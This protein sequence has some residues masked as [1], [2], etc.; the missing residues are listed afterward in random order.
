MLAS[1]QPA[2]AALTVLLV[3]V[4]ITLAGIYLTL[5]GTWPRLDLLPYEDTLALRHPSMKPA[6]ARIGMSLPFFAV[7]GYLL[8]F[9]NLPYVYPFVP[10]LVAMYLYFRGIFRYWVNHHTSYF[11]TNRRVVHMYRFAWL[12]TTEIPV[13]SINSISESRSFIEM[14]SRRG[15]VVVASG[16]GARHKVRIQEIDSPGPLARAI[17]HLIQ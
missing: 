13:R 8:E 17:R 11:V 4:V 5:V 14:I 1:E 12:T 7:A 6:Y 3:G 2:W 15:S 16:I 10:F 9:T